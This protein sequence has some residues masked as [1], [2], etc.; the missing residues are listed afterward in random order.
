L[1]KIILASYRMI[2]ILSLDVAAG[3]MI[4]ASFFAHLMNVVI[5]PQGL[6]S[7]GLT[8]WI[9]YTADHLL[10]AKKLKQDA[11]TERH[12]FHQR[13]FKSL[14]ALL[15]G[16]LLIDLTQIY[17]IRSIVFID[18]LRLAFLVGIY[19]LVQQRIGFSKELLGTLL[20]TGGVLLIP[21]SVNNQLSLRIILLIL[22]FGITAWINLLLF[23]WIDKQRDEKDRHHSFATTFGLVVTQRIL[24]FLFVTTASLTTIQLVMF[25]KDSMATLILTAMTTLLLLIFLKRSYF[26]KEDRYRLLGDAVFLL[27]ILYILF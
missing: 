14:S 9:I 4:C 26:E 15:V 20:Y 27:P 22:Q 6:I 17:F 1:M 24:L 3:A 16:A 10:D 7:L 5:L 11:S 19:F 18:G 13:H 25:P 8:V 23:S 2:N 12:R 21:L